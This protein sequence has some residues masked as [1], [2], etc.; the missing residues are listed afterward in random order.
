MNNDFQIFVKGKN[1]VFDLCHALENIPKKDLYVKQRTLT[2]AFNIVESISKENL[3]AKCGEDILVNI[4]ML[5]FMLEYL[6]KQKYINE[7]KLKTLVYKLT[8]I[9]KVTRIWLK[10]RRNNERKN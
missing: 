4:S 3:T 8:E 1:L 6:Y 5:D 10:N 2:Y 7:K 9:N